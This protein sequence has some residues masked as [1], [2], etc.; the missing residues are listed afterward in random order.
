MSGY[1][2]CLVTAGDKAVARKIAHALIS[3]QLA[4]CVSFASGVSSIYRWKDKIEENSEIVMIIKT[5][6]SL[7]DEVIQC[8]KKHHNYELPE[9]LFIPVEGSKD[10]LDWIGANTRFAMGNASDS[11][12]NV[13]EI[14]ET[15]E[16]ENGSEK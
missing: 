3:D 14:F 12:D 4:A 5:R 6:D 9:I 11:E 16:I 8:V 15:L 10:Y 7:C 13:P 2:I 1:S